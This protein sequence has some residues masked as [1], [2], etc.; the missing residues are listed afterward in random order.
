MGSSQSDECQI[1]ALVQAWAVLSGAAAPDRAARAMDAAEERLVSEKDGII[2]LLTPPFRHS[3]HDPGYIQGYAAGVRENGGQ[4]THA[5]LWVVGALAELGRRDRAAQ[6]LEM[7]APLS[8]ARIPQDVERY[9]VE[10]YVVAAD[11]YG[12]APHVGRGGWTWY[13][14]SA[15]WMLRVGL[16]SI[17][18]FRVQ[19]G[20]AIE[21]RPCIPPDWPEYRISYRPKGRA[22]MFEIH[23]SNPEG[24]TGRVKSAR[25]DGEPWPTL[26]G[27]V[28]VPVDDDSLDHELEIVLE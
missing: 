13:T 25:L 27:A 28:V 1:D 6:L 10:P 24:K 22:T 11:V 2:R 18:G 14:G 17:L 4:Y 21:I 7:L 15:G 5:A 16:E 20:R 9:R 19:Q 8:H 3:S 26:D 12:E 23:V